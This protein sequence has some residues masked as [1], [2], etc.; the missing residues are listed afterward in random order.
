MRRRRAAAQQ[1]RSGAGVIELAVLARSV[2]KVL[3]KPKT[4]HPVQ[5]VLKILHL[6][7]NLITVLVQQE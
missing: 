4:W 2:L 7:Q 1:G 3:T 6:Q 5:V